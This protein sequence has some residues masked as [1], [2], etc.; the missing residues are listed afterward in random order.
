M[1]TF[2]KKVT[3]GNV[4]DDLGLSAEVT[5]AA[6]VKS[7]ILNKIIDI[8]ERRQL[9]PRELELI[10]DKP[11]PRVSEL[12]NGKIGSLSIEKLLDYLERLCGEVTIS[13]KVK[14]VA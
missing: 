1:S 13:I 14:K 12:L 8:I 6:K 3:R 11:Q 2:K 4:F 10:L 5:L 7:D 9:S